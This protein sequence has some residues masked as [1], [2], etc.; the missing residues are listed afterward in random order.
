MT[1]ISD[2]KQGLIGPK[3]STRVNIYGNDYP[4]VIDSGAECSLCSEGYYNKIEKS[5]G[6]PLTTLNIKVPLLF[7]ANNTKITAT[8]I[9]LIDLIINNKNGEKLELNNCP[10]I[11][12]KIVPD[13]IIIGMN[14]IRHK[15]LNIMNMEGIYH[16][17]PK[18]KFPIETKIFNIEVNSVCEIENSFHIF[19]NKD[20]Q[21]RKNVEKTICT[22]PLL[23]INFQ[24]TEVI[25]N[26][27]S[28]H[29]QNREILSK[30]TK[31]GQI[32]LAV[33]PNYDIYLPKG[34]SIGNAEKFDHDSSYTFGIP[35][36]LEMAAKKPS[37][38]EIECI[39]DFDD[40]FIWPKNPIHP[41]LDCPNLG[42]IDK[43][44]F[45]IEKHKFHDKSPDDLMSSEYNYELKYLIPI[46]SNKNY[47]IPFYEKKG[48]KFHRNSKGVVV[49]FVRS[50]ASLDFKSLGLITSLSLENKN[51]LICVTTKL[52]DRC[53]KISLHTLNVFVN[54][55]MWHESKAIYKFD[56]YTAEA[57]TTYHNE[58]NEFYHG[59]INLYF[60]MRTIN[61]D[62]LE[63]LFS[64]LTKRFIFRSINLRYDPLTVNDE[65][66]KILE[67]VNFLPYFNDRFYTNEFNCKK[68]VVCLNKFSNSKI[69]LGKPNYPLNPHKK[70]D[71][72]LSNPNIEWS[73]A[74]DIDQK[75][76]NR[77]NFIDQVSATDQYF[78]D[79]LSVVGQEEINEICPEPTLGEF[80]KKPPMVQNWR[81]TICWDGTLDKDKK[82]LLKVIEKYEKSIQMSDLDLGEASDRLPKYKI[83]LKP[84]V[85][86]PENL[87]TYPI[88]PHFSALLETA[89]N[90]MLAKG[91]IVETSPK[92]KLYFSN[93]FVVLRNS[94]IKAKFQ[95]EKRLGVKSTLTQKS[96]RLVVDFRSLNNAMVTENTPSAY[97]KDHI[98][99]FNGYSLATIIDI[100]K[101]YPSLRVDES[102]QNLLAFKYKGSAYKFKRTI[103]G[104]RDL[105]L[106]FNRVIDL[107]LEPLVRKNSFIIEKGNSL[108]FYGPGNFQTKEN[109]KSKNELHIE[110]KN[111]GVELPRIKYGQYANHYIDD[112]YLLSWK[113]PGESEEDL[114]K[115]HAQMI[116]LCLECL[117]THGFKFNIS[118]IQ[119]GHRSSVDFLG[120]RIDPLK[121]I[122][123]TSFKNLF[124]NYPTP[125]KKVE[126]YKFLG[127]IQWHLNFIPNINNVLSPLYHKLGQAKTLHE[128]ICLDETELKSFHEACNKMK[129]VQF[130]F[131]FDPQAPLVISTDASYT[132]VGVTLTQG[133][134]VVLYFSK[135]FSAHLQST[136][137]SLEKEGLG[138]I[139]GVYN[140]TV[141]GMIRQLTEKLTLVCDCRSLVSLIKHSPFNAKLSRWVNKLHLLPHDFE[142]KLRVN[143]NL[144]SGPD[145]LSK[146]V[147]PQTPSNLPK[148]SFKELAIN[149]VKIP[150][151][152]IENQ[153]VTLPELI[154]ATHNDDDCVAD[155]I[156]KPVPEPK[157]STLC[158]NL[159]QIQF[160]DIIAE[161]I[162][163]EQATTHIEL[164][165]CEA[166]DPNLTSCTIE[167]HSAINEYKNVGNYPARMT[168]NSNK[169]IISKKPVVKNLFRS[170]FDFFENLSYEKLINIQKADDSIQSIIEKILTF[171]KNIGRYRVINGNLLVHLKN[172]HAKEQN[173][174]LA[175]FSIVIPRYHAIQMAGT[176]H[177]I[178]HT[179]YRMVYK[180]ISRHYFNEKLLKICQEICVCC[181]ICAINRT[182]TS[183]LFYGRVDR[184]DLPLQTLDLD[185][186]Y[187]NKSNKEGWLQIRCAFSGFLISTPCTYFTA[188]ET[189]RIIKDVL[190]L[191]GYRTKV[192]RSDRAPNIIYNELFNQFA[193]DRGLTLKTM[194]PN[195]KFNHGLIERSIRD[196]KYI[197]R[198]LEQSLK[199]TWKEVFYDAIRV[200]NQAP[201]IEHDGT[202]FTPYQLIYDTP[203]EIIK[204]PFG[205]LK[206]L[207]KSNRQKILDRVKSGYEKA[208]IKNDKLK[209]NLLY[210]DKLNIGSLCYIKDPKAGKNTS[211]YFN[212][213][214][215]IV[216]RKEFQL[217]L[218]PF[219][220]KSKKDQHVKVHTYL[221]KS[222]KPR[223]LQTFG[224]LN[225]KLKALLG[226]PASKS[227]FDQESEKNLVDYLSDNPE[228]SSGLSLT[229]TSSNESSDNDSNDMSIQNKIT[230]KSNNITQENY[231][232][233]SIIPP[234]SDN[235]RRIKTPKN[236][237]NNKNIE[238]FDEEDQL[239]MTPP[240]SPIL[241]PEAKLLKSNSLKV[242]Q[243]A[244]N[245]SFR[246]KN[247]SNKSIME[248]EP[249]DNRENKIKNLIMDTKQDINRQIKDL[250]KV[251]SPNKSNNKIKP[252]DSDSLVNKSTSYRE[253][254]KQFMANRSLNKTAINNSKILKDIS[255]Y[256]DL[257]I[258]RDS[259]SEPDIQEP[260]PE[261]IKNTKQKYELG[262]TP[263]KETG[264]IP[265]KRNR[266]LQGMDDKNIVTSSRERKKRER[267]DL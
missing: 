93:I 176:R 75:T 23:Q 73:D 166:V 224:E 117:S 49:F 266:L 196:T 3:A 184:S 138:L 260:L 178:S 156:G 241:S 257:D 38:L 235:F 128:K 66:I 253:D 203:N 215:L 200:L 18:Q 68:C 169:K 217:T 247:N 192:L 88:S 33:K 244:K 221:V 77:V 87:A 36:V 222:F 100:A 83:T 158:K 21:F 103:E 123:L 181:K 35:E 107:V 232:K 141:Y 251:V 193:K 108:Q 52:C 89:I 205:G 72:F 53:K 242:Q 157:N 62:A 119:L 237:K 199:L 127:L 256:P 175:D 209:E 189:L 124:E 78:T 22:S 55:R 236:N 46:P 137:N 155:F 76:L 42:M 202:M 147:E 122:P 198:C 45:A 118:K 56:E 142:I 182:K 254:F 134:R 32:L 85:K 240:L 246:D 125:K 206:S 12:C 190:R 69:L 28:P 63:N 143:K 262:A 179:G 74:I 132:G 188:A 64:M 152:L 54:S 41:M 218:V 151:G 265:K 95:E 92:D 43:G 162:L 228:L 204:D 213:L 67:N 102:T 238:N 47:T 153:L 50:L 172:K 227:I 225:S 10:F 207:S 229:S 51:F 255:I 82:W 11:I 146:L 111:S 27:N 109:K 140:P 6:R 121:Y 230:H 24:P 212:N 180:D 116:D 61:E 19:L 94:A 177:A 211:Q 4:A 16:L 186:A 187:W 57:D 264:A 130:L 173:L 234:T 79:K 160:K 261:P 71:D 81:D 191:T 17:Y 249:E 115:K 259:L 154:E 167:E 91:M 135:L 148:T 267:L 263:K 114:I 174:T 101:A 15:K 106:H 110:Q 104:L 245:A 70:R 136:L 60:H 9:V 150:K 26:I 129:E 248:F 30:L 185:H 161:S 159:Q 197:L 183:K 243:S 171:N 99:N 96:I 201:R 59:S 14:L 112:L 39:C 113:E 194:M 7:A 105:P 170:S 98:N 133:D 164:I 34:T 165:L 2:A 1:E 145:A 239:F 231:S 208:K 223:S 84:D 40:Q 90:K 44:G 65:Q 20:Y 214:Y 80:N 195:C 31:Y 149:Q 25:I 210:K 5:L 252:Q 29:F 258:I 220:D 37:I 163:S 226:H 250:W 168:R 233:L 58:I 86:F 8:K 97:L 219:L 126:L 216:D 139:L 13:K 48:T 131:H 120:F 144:Y